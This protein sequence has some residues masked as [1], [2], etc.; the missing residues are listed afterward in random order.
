M[1]EQENQE[2]EAKIQAERKK[3]QELHTFHKQQLEKISYWSA[4]YGVIYKAWKTFY[5][6]MR[7]IG[8]SLGVMVSIIPP[9]NAVVKGMIS[10]VE[11]IEAVFISTETLNRRTVKSLNA[12]A[13]AGLTIAALVLTANPVTAFLGAILLIAAIG[14]TTIKDAFFWYK[15]SRDVRRAKA[16][17]QEIHQFIETSCSNDLSNIKRIDSQIHELEREQNTQDQIEDMKVKRSIYI[18]NIDTK[19][20]S[21]FSQKK[22]INYNLNKLLIDRDTARKNFIVNGMTLIGMALFTVV[23]FTAVSTLLINP[24][25]LTSIGIALLGV[26]TIIAVKNKFFNKPKVKAHPVTI[27][28]HDIRH[29]TEHHSHVHEDTLKIIHSLTHGTREMDKTALLNKKDHL[30]QADNTPSFKV[31]ELSKKHLKSSSIDDEEGESESES[32]HNHPHRS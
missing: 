9:I 3:N 25:V 5:E 4:M 18:R 27:K 22:I 12:I 30:S 28:K 24:I 20:N 14:L 31:N 16:L 13:S 15:T 29:Y 19:V 2:L 21:N 8:Q 6:L 32:P 10:F 7:T 11:L 1:L 17:N 23:A 26:A